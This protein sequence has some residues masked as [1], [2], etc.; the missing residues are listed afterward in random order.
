M[1]KGYKVAH[2][3]LAGLVRFLFR[4]KVEG[5]K[6]DPGEGGILLCSNHITLLDPICISAV[7]RKTEPFYMAKKELFKIPILSSIL[8]A[9]GSYPVNRGAGDLGAIHKTV[10]L[11]RAGH[12]VGIFPQGT[13]CRGVSLEDTKFKNGAALVLSKTEV[14]VLP[15]RVKVKNN[16]WCPFK[17]IEIV[18][19][20]KIEA[21]MLKLD[22]EKNKSEE[23]ARITSLIFERIKEL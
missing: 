15:V 13:R 14:P 12:C 9:L 23:M 4:V 22:P 5:L 8:R 7:L 17:K 20:E 19:G 10:D 2:T 18:I 3:I 21:D 1:R 6:N 11:L 16:K